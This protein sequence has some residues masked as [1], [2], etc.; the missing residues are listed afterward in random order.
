VGGSDQAPLRLVLRAIPLILDTIR[1][2]AARACGGTDPAANQ[3]I[4]VWT[5]ART[6]L[7]AV[8]LGGDSMRVISSDRERSLD[9]DR[10]VT[11]QHV[12]IRHTDIA[13]LWRSLPVDSVARVGYVTREGDSTLFWA[14]SLDVLASDSFTANHCFRVAPKTD[15]GQLGLAF[16]PAGVVDGVT[17]I[18]GTLWLEPT[19]FALQR[20]DFSYTNAPQVFQNEY[21]SGQLI[22][23]RTANGLWLISNWSLVLPQIGVVLQRNVRTVSRLQ[24]L[25]GLREVGG[26]VTLAFIGKDTAWSGRLLALSGSVTDS[27]SR[28]PV[29]DARVSLREANIESITDSLGRFEFPPVAP[30]SF[31]VEVRTA[32]LDSMRA[33]HRVRMAIADSA[34]ELPIVVPNASMIATAMCGP[35]GAR[36][37]ASTGGI[38]VGALSGATRPTMVRA[39]W[40]DSVG[41]HSVTATSDSAGVFRA[42]G[43]PLQSRLWLRAGSDSLAS[44]EAEVMITGA[45]IARVSLALLDA[46]RAG[47]SISGV[48]LSDSSSR[49]VADA[50]VSIPDAGLSVRSAA[51]GSF[52]L[53]RI[54]AGTHNIVV[55]RIGYGALATSLTFKPGERVYRR[56]LLGN[57]VALD[58]VRVVAQANG[59]WVG[60]FEER[61][62]LGLGSFLTRSDLAKYDGG[63]LRV[64]LSTVRGLKFDTRTGQIALNSRSNCRVHWY[65]DRSLIYSGRPG[66]PIP[67][68]REFPPESIE[69]IE[70]YA[71]PAEL[72][73]ELSGL[74]SPCGV[75][76]IHTRE[77]P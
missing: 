69:A 41:R 49:P 54:P 15:S 40:M 36:S 12:S 77:S 52:H 70:Y 38:I 25:S 65:L 5:Q 72:P 59:T 26:E 22:F 1:V 73:A 56:V 14:P 61:Q 53:S 19:S 10:H 13:S 27:T 7:M 35:A 50:E 39:D 60:E 21:A 3:A 8:V 4:D 48:V 24:R 32:S 17:E 9:K 37:D 30:D 64:A 31:T 18:K 45:R 68:Q 75:L 74:N 55:R 46:A 42:C 6:A 23:A 47:A 33:V 43:L 20:I 34:Q 67:Q 11:S 2:S 58:E 44:D 29:R 51:D 66:E 16:E 57:V 71:S 76:V 62:R 63:Q 28:A